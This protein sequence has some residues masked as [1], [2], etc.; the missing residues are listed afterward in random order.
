MIWL[1]ARPLP[2]LS[3]ANKV[4]SL[5]QISFM[6]PVEPIESLMVGGGGGLSEAGGRSK[7]ALEQES[8]VLYKAMNH[9]TL[10][11][12]FVSILKI[13]RNIELVALN[14]LLQ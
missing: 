2:P 9:S 12:E 14:S 4:V 5:S 1:L 7:I 3:H 10:S 8:L 11:G 13:F 6:S